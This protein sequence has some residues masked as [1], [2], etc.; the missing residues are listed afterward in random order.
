MPGVVQTTIMILL[1]IYTLFNK[2]GG[3]NKAGTSFPPGK[4]LKV[5]F[6]VLIESLIILSLLVIPM[7][8]KTQSLHLKYT[9][10]RS[11]NNIGWLKLEKITDGKKIFLKVNSEIKARFIF[12]MTVATQESAYFENGK[13]VYS[14]LVRKTNGTTKL[15]KQTKLVA[16]KYEVMEDGKKQIL[17]FSEIGITILSLYFQEPVNIR[18]VYSENH[19]SYVQVVKTTDGGYFVKFP[20]GNSNHFYYTGGTCTRVKINH[21]FYSAEIILN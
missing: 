6:N 15:D 11:G 3:Q 16:N 1:H 21:T 2:R 17:D 18:E 8:S 20:D 14:S 10:K 7:A 5:C 4:L 9:I 19:E 13:L 12:M